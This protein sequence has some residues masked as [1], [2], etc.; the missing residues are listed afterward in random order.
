MLKL[1][2]DSAGDLPVEWIER[3][4]IHVVPINIHIGEEVYLEDVDLSKDQFYRRVEETGRIPKTSQPTPQQY[5]EVYRRIAE[6]GNVILSIHLTSKLSGTYESA[7][8]AAVEM[9]QEGIEVIPYDTR[10]G[11]GIQGYMCC[12]ARVMAQQGASLEEIIHRLDEIRDQT[13]IILALQSLDFAQ[14]SGRVQMLE[15]ILASLLKIKPVIYLREGAL[16]IG[17]KVRSR[18]TSLDY[19]LQEMADRVGDSLVNAAVMHAH[20]PQMADAF[21]E[22]VQ[23]VLNCKHFFIEEVSIGIASNLGPGTIGI[24][25]YPVGK[26]VF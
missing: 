24:I 8:I 23:Q 3:Y 10:A 26:G 19:V 22:K 18:L 21:S 5:Q 20:D 9:A 4:Q 25:A 7:E 2:M 11:T 12:E 16:E 1:V 15:S 14:K 13:E 6:P 17:K